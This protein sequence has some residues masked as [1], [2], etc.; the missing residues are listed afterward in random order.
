[1]IIVQTFYGRL[2]FSGLVV[3]L[4]LGGFFVAWHWSGTMLK[5]SG[6][7]RAVIVGGEEYAL[8]IADT[9]T[10]RSLGLGERDGLCARCGMLFIFDDE[11][12]HGFWMKGMR[13]P[14]DIVWLREGVVVHIEQR[15][16]PADASV[17]QPPVAADQVLEF[18]AGVA[19]GLRI[20]E[21]V[22]FV[23]GGR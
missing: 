9:E 6:F 18:N 13:F 11:A 20:G 8:E 16:S 3:V 12:Q 7:P 4:V 14:L 17:Y 23:F 15:I 5:M 22:P 19:D 2:V 1:M 10:K 21:L